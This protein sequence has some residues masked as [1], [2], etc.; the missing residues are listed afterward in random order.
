MSFDP[1]IR[2]LS[3]PQMKVAEIGA[4]TFRPI[5]RG[6]ESAT[7]LLDLAI[8]LYVSSVFFKSGLTKIANWESTLFLFEN[9]YHV[10]V[11]PP[12]AAAY[13]GTATELAMPILLAVGFG[14]RFSAAVLF[15]FNIVAAT[16]YPELSAAG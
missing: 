8:R 1:D 6:I 4:W 14:A 2:S 3:R 15:V 16:S 13:L 11:L 9:E 5:L 12:E 10:P 7:P